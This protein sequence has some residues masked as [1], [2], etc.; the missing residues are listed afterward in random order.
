MKQ[1]FA[2]Y[3]SI[4]GSNQGDEFVCANHWKASWE[5]NGWTCTMLNKSHATISPLLTKLM[6]HLIQMNIKGARAARY[7][8]WC[9]LHA[10][11]GGWMSDYDVANLGFSK[12]EAE[13]ME[14]DGPHLIVGEPCYLFYASKDHLGY[15][16]KKF[17]E[18]PPY[19][20]DY[21]VESDVL[22]N[23]NNSLAGIKSKLFHA[24]RNADGTRVDQMRESLTNERPI[25]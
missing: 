13:A 14:K 12:N 8:R 25:P 5:A 24:K 3:E 10:A 4:P 17:L 1:I 22:Q 9:A 16:I 23:T 7:V 21:P 20:P 6:W 15:M 19:N 18:L 11:G 2:Y